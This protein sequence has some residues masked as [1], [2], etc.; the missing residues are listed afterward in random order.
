MKEMKGLRNVGT[1]REFQPT[2]SVRESITM[3][4]DEEEQRPIIGRDHE[5]GAFHDILGIPLPITK[6]PD[7]NQTTVVVIAGESGVGRTRVLEACIAMA[8]KKGVMVMSGT[9]TKHDA[10]VHRLRD[11][12]I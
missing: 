7:P 12:N 6:E 10:E 1:I 2:V 5:L 4:I 8:L 11:C 3:Q 9:L